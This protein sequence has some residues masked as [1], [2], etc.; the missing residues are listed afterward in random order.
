MVFSSTSRCTTFRH[1]VFLFREK[2]NY[3][4]TISSAFTDKHAGALDASAPD[5][6]EALVANQASL[7]LPVETVL[8]SATALNHV[9]VALAGGAEPFAEGKAAFDLAD[10]S[11]ELVVGEALGTD[12]SVCFEAAVGQGL[13]G[14]VVSNEEIAFT[15]NATV[16]VEG[17]AVGDHT[18]EAF[19]DEGPEA[20]LTGVVGVLKLASKDAVVLAFPKDQREFALAL[21]ALVLVVVDFAEFD[22]QSAGGSNFSKAVSAVSADLTIS[23]QT[24]IHLLRHL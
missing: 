24:A 11:L 9:V 17:F 7:V 4:R 21:G 20:L 2:F 10:T 16:V 5:H 12:S 8:E 23:F 13:A 1:I 19:Q 14:S 15:G 3:D 22:S 18:V 6:V